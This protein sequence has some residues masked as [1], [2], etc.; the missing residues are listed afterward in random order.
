MELDNK[1]DKF[2]SISDALTR[3]LFSLK[4]YRTVLIKKKICQTLQA[5][6]YSYIYVK[7]YCFLRFVN[8]K[9]DELGI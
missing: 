6:F 7:M 3:Y 8:S 9:L 5:A 4:E 2:F 1:I